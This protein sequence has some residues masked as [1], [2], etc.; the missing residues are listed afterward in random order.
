MYAGRNYQAQVVMS[1]STRY[2]CMHCGFECDAMVTGIGEGSGRSP[3]FLD[4]D[5]ARDRARMDASA[6]ASNNMHY[7]LRSA[8]CPKCGKHDAGARREVYVLSALRGLLFGALLGGVV[9]VLFKGS[10]TGWGAGIVTAL[11]VMIAMTISRAQRMLTGAI[12]HP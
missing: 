6:G 11:V 1:E 10:T 9:L 8:V 12:L 7:A 5:G 4:N 2:Q 3:Y